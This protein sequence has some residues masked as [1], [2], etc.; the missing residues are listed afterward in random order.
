[1]KIFSIICIKSY[2]VG[3]L[4]H[5]C[6]ILQVWQSVVGSTAGGVGIQRTPVLSWKV[7]GGSPRLVN[8]KVNYQ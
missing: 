5:D 4:S 3:R 7:G 8:V 2:S 6:S 1:M